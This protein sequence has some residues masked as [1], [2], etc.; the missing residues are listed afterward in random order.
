[1]ISVLCGAGSSIPN[2]APDS[3]LSTPIRDLSLERVAALD[4]D[5][6][7]IEDAVHS[8]TADRKPHYLAPWGSGEDGWYVRW[9]PL[10]ASVWQGGLEVPNPEFSKFDAIV[11]TEV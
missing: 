9:A 6:N 5:P 4:I 2:D 11:S 1:L 8:A 3:H 7:V 10:E